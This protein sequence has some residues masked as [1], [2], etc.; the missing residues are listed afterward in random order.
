MPMISG[1]SL[2][3]TMIPDPSRGE[4]VDDSIDLDFAPMSTPRVGSSRMSTPGRRP[5]QRQSRTFCWL[6]PDRLPTVT[7]GLAARTQALPCPRR[8][9]TREPRFKT[10]FGVCIPVN[11]ADIDIVAARHVEEQSQRLP[12]LGEIGDAVLQRPPEVR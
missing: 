12:V 2:E 4:L 7:S 8:G 11:D 3:M 10:P 1:S 9:A 6:P 5:S